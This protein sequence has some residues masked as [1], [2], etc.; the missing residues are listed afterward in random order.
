MPATTPR[1]SLPYLQPSQAQKHVTHNEALQLLD[2]VVQLRVLGFG[3]TTPPAAPAAG[4]VHALGP[5]ATGDW[6]GQD[7]RLALWDGTGWQFL[8][9]RDGWR[10]WDRGAQQLR[11][12]T[13]GAWAPVAP[14]LQNLAG[15]GIG[16]ASDATNRLAVAAN[17]TL[18]SHAGAGHQVKV[19]KAAAADTASLLFQ[20]NWTGHAEMGLAGG[21]DFS[22]KVSD[23]SAWSTALTVARATGVV[24]LPQGAAIN[25]PVTGAAVQSSAIDGTAGRLLTTGAFGLGGALPA[26]GDAGVTDGSLVP[27]LYAYDTA[28]G[29]TGGPASVTRGTLLH[30]RRGAS[31]G[32]T[33][34]LVVEAGSASGVY[35]G[36]VFGRSRSGGAWGGWTCGSVQ[37]STA[38]T[39][40]RCLRQQDGT[41]TCWHTITTSASAETVWT[42]PQAFASTTGLVVTLGVNGSALTALFPRHTAKG[43][44][45]VSLS[46]VNGSGTRVAASL[47]MIAV[48]RWF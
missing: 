13:E 15:V 4:D 5:G 44:A 46:V 45:S 43:T 19:N 9:P 20:S 42:F 33:Q 7:G 27:G 37:D 32:E 25:G 10:A 17:A 21:L 29:S 12:W 18:L 2:A 22:L 47:D 30:S 31:L 14:P 16:T 1:L 11:V 28:A 48:G 35:A 6:S 34:L 26:L 24:S 38:G 41:Q 40:G 23:G 36:L 8:S 39:N 3:A